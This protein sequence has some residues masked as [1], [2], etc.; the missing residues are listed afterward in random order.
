MLG[1]FGAISPR[2]EAFLK[3]RTST[4]CEND[5]REISAMGNPTI[6]TSSTSVGAN[7]ANK[8]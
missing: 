2:N 6:L 1:L 7:L 8:E 5:I 4:S 3:R